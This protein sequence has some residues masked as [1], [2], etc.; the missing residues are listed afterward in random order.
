[1]RGKSRI[2]AKM[3]LIVP[4][5]C[6]IA[7]LL[8]AFA[9]DPVSQITRRL[10]DFTQSEAAQP[11]AM[12]TDSDTPGEGKVFTGASAT[13][14]VEAHNQAMREID[15]LHARSPEQREAALAAIRKFAQKSTMALAYQSTSSD[16]NFGGKQIELYQSDDASY[17]VDPVTN[18]V[19][20]VT[21]DSPEQAEEVYGGVEYTPDQ[22]QTLAV[23]YLQAHS[24]CFSKQ[25]GTLKFGSGNKNQNYFFRWDSSLPPSGDGLA[26]F[27]QVGVN[28]KGVI[29]SYIDSICLGL[30]Q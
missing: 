25:V 8:L 16:P 26:P 12:T 10:T 6:A 15:A 24:T 14:V 13:H 11:G 7:I 27:M 23:S 3:I 30:A 17:A 9:P 5:L 1:M 2:N 21:L 20:G 22:L 28:T 4:A 19:V 18:S 29:F